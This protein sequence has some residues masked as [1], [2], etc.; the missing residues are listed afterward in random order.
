MIFRA[1]GTPISLNGRYGILDH[2]A[3]RPANLITCPTSQSRL[4]LVPSVRGS[5]VPEPAMASFRV[6]AKVM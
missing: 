4:P 3:L 5:Y 2:S 1:A 6:L